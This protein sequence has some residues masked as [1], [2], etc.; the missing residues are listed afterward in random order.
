MRSAKTRALVTCCILAGCFTIF[1][2]R[3]V[4]LQVTMGQEYAEKAADR[5]IEKQ[6]IYAKRGIIQDVNGEL[7]AQNEPMR[8]IIADG[9]LIER[10][11]ETAALLAGPL[12]MKTGVVLEKLRTKRFS[13]TANRSL[14]SKYIVLKRKV[15][16]RVA[17]ALQKEL[18]A[19]HLRGIAFKPDSERIY[20]NGQMLCHVIGAVNS[21]GE[22]LEGIEKTFDHHLRGHDGFRYTEHDPS[23]NEIVPYRGQ[24]RAPRDGFGVRLT[25]DMRLQS[26]VEDELDAAVQEFRPKMITC[27]LMRPQTGEILAMASRPHFDLNQK[28]EVPLE[29]RKN[30]AIT[31]MVE[32][33]STFKIVPVAGAL[34]E[35]AVRPDTLIFC[36]NGYY[37]WCRLRI[38]K[39]TRN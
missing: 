13:K 25:I 20:P 34:A 2:F 9:S 11:E 22:G 19:Q 35:R 4:H 31:D 17:T 23:G 21:E 12:E 18:R 5:N 10:F 28:T 37:S 39:A 3:L 14:P 24:E 7:L 1:S 26:I 8:T 33:G 38:T 36:E 32:P 6:I 15:S 29:H 27:I 30:R 16:E